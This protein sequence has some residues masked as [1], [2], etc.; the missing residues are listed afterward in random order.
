METQKRSKL[1]FFKV[2]FSK[3]AT[4]LE[5]IF[6]RQINRGDCFQSLW[7]FQNVRTL[8]KKLKQTI[9]IDV[10]KLVKSLEKSF[11]NQNNIAL[12]PTTITYD[13]RE[14]FQYENMRMVFQYKA[15][16]AKLSKNT[17]AYAKTLQNLL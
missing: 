1:F 11:T 2:R 4:K 8:N 17:C 13:P 14:V 6:Q 7:P 12:Q 16:F 15:K 5:T 9:L 3:E 10:A